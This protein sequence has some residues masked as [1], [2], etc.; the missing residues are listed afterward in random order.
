M[1]DKDV[2][3]YI[4]KRL[5][6][7]FPRRVDNEVGTWA[8]AVTQ[9]TEVVLDGAG[10]IA[11]L[12]VKD[13]LTIAP[14]ILAAI[15]DLKDLRSL[16]LEQADIA[17]I[18]PLRSLNKL[19]WL[20]LHQNRLTELP[21]V[22]S[23]RTL[24]ALFISSNHIARIDALAEANKLSALM[25]SGNRVS[26]LDAIAEAPLHS[27]F[28]DNNEIERLPQAGM[29]GLMT[30]HCGGNPI[31]SLEPLAGLER[32]HTLSV[33]RARISDLAPIRSNA[34]L[35]YLDL[36]SNQIV[37]LKP[38]SSL[39]ELQWL[40]ADDNRI[41]DLS[42]IVSLTK[43]QTLSVSNNPITEPSDE[44]V[45]AGPE[46][47]R[48]YFKQRAAGEEP[49]FEAKVLFVGEPSAGKT[50][51]RNKLLD[52]AYK[53][54][55]DN[56]STLG[57][58]IHPDWPFPWAVDHAKT[59]HAHLWDFGGQNIQYYIHQFFLTER[60][61]YILVHNAR[62][63]AEHIEYW[64]NIIELL[65]KDCPVLV[66]G[67][68]KHIDGVI[69][70]LD[71]AKYQSQYP[72]LKLE[73][74]EVDLGKEDGRLAAVSARA[75]ALASSLPHV[76]KP[77]PKSWL[78]VRRGIERLHAEGKKHVPFTDMEELC[79]TAGIRETADQLVL[80][81][82]LHDLGIILYYANDEVLEQVVFLDPAWVTEAMYA[83]LAK[84]DLGPRFTQRALFDIWGSRFT[85]REKQLLLRLMRK[86]E[87][88]LC[89][90]LEA[91]GRKSSA[92]DTEYLI[93]QLL[94]DVAPANANTWTTASGLRF[95]YRYAFMPAG[96]VG[97]LCVRL[98]D[99]IRKDSANDVWKSGFLL[100]Q[101]DARA[102]IL[103]TRDH[104]QRQIIDISINGPRLAAQQLLAVIR[105]E[106]DRVHQRSFRQVS[107][108]PLVPCYCPQCEPAEQ[109]TLFELSRLELH[110]QQ[111]EDT[112]TCE[113][114]EKFT[115]VSIRR[116]LEG[117]VDPEET[118]KSVQVGF[119][120]DPAMFAQERT[121]GE[122]IRLLS[123]RLPPPIIVQQHVHTEQSQAAEATTTAR[124]VARSAPAPAPAEKP[125]SGVAR[126]TEVMNLVKVAVAIVFAI[127]AFFGYKTIS[128][129]ESKK[130]E[131]PALVVNVAP[132]PLVTQPA[133][134]PTA[135]EPQPPRTT[136]PAASAAAR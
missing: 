60:S 75:Q 87:F 92:A 34:S 113:R 1:R 28:M 73:F 99:F 21:F 24:H 94:A 23:A 126:A 124:A 115:K 16:I 131:P 135:S 29:Q 114:R 35:T 128:G 20:S 129:T 41:T 100:Q 118:T 26:D 105:T 4:E 9:S 45:Q 43:L 58:D 36:D 62:K 31:A 132:T 111:R 89:Y 110:V 44:I 86:D 50:S 74:L 77:I 104:D 15:G 123:G 109:P 7:K 133:P 97:R 107:A 82:L 54:K 13:P 84:K 95:Q 47:I 12:A 106:I 81:R 59:V 22:P 72:K 130:T 117:V 70:K 37:D 88:D 64:F 17:D 53:L 3:A 30:L 57:V 6:F 14:D 65:G 119:P 10:S 91:R 96:L 40:S 76:G 49:L 42:P 108:E 25:L 103:Q 116:L 120:D 11:G 101:G 127:L 56:R 38:L 85:D 66:V 2:L 134:A 8:A 55:V 67:N 63:D 122:L 83:I 69:A 52:P 90:E 39:S 125:K 27:L 78:E 121:L 102:R 80:V 5:D 136:K 33:V 79:R 71:A 98:S 18:G 48:S 19:F 46:A 32:L 51:L 68:E 112:I 93:P 61:L